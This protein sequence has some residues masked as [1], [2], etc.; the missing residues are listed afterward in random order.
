MQLPKELI[1]EFVKATKD[2]TKPSDNSILYGTATVEAGGAVYVAID[3]STELTPVTKAATVND[4]ERVMVTIKDHTATIVGN[5]SSP[6]ARS[7]DVEDLGA[8]IGEFDLVIADKVSTSQLAAQ[9]ARIDELVADNVTIKGDLVANKASIENLEAEDVKING[10]LEAQKASIDE[11]DTKKIDAETV[12][13]EYATIEKLNAANASIKNLEAEDVKINGTLDAQKAVI[14]TLDTTYATIKNLNATNAEVANLKADK[15]DADVVEATYATIEKLNATNANVDNLSA[16]HGEFKELTTDKFEAID[17]TIDNLDSTYATV[18]NLNAEKARIDD[19]EANSLTANHAVIKGLEADVADINTLIFGSAS[20]DVIQTSFA[21]AVIA[22]LGD[23][24]IKSAMIDNVSANKIIAG[25]IIT[26]N[27]SVKSEDGK[28]LI[29]DETI[30]ISDDARVRVQIGKDAAGDYSINIWDAEGNLMFSE[31]GITDNSIKEAI[32]RNDMVKDDANIS[33]SKLDISSLF[34]EINGSNETIKANRIYLDEENQTLDVSFTQ[35]T[36][37]MEDLDDR[38]VSQGTQL[39]V[40]QGQISSKVWQQDIN[41]ATDELGG[42]INTLNTNYSSLNQTVNGLKTTVASHTTQIASKADGSTVTAVSNK[43]TELESNLDGFKSTV[44]STYATAEAVDNIRIGGR[45]LLLN[46][47]TFSG[48]NI[49]VNQDA[50]IGGTYQGLNIYAHDFSKATSGSADILQFKQIYPEKLGAEY[51]LSFYAKGSG[52]MFTYFYGDTGYLQCAT[53]TRS[54]GEVTHSGDGSSGWSLTDQWTRYWVTWK[55]KDTGDITVQK[56]VL[57]RLLSGAKV[58]LCGIQLEKGNKASDWSP[59][60]EDMAT[61]GDLESTSKSI[62]QQTANSITAEV[63]SISIGGR[64]LLLN[65]NEEAT[66]N[67]YCIKGYV[68]SSPLV[69]GEQYTLS[70]CVTPAAGV[71]SFKA[72][73][74]GGYVVLGNLVVDGTE[75]QVLSC[76]F[77]AQY[78][79]GRTPTDDKAYANVR[80]YR[81]P[82]D[83]TVTANST[84]HWAKVEKGNK[85]TDWSPAPEEMASSKDLDSLEIGGRNLIAGTDKTTEYVGNKGTSTYKDVWFATTIEPPKGTEYIVSF[86]AKA[87][88]AQD[89][90]CFFYNPN[91]TVNAESSTGQTRAGADGQCSVTITTEWKRYWVKWTQTAATDPKDVIVGRNET[92][93][94]IYIRAVKFEAGNKATDWTPAPEDT[95]KDIAELSARIEVNEDN[96]K[97]QVS[98]TNTLKSK[99]STLE[100]R[101]DGFDVSIEDAKKSATDF[102]SYDG[103]NGLQVG[104]KQGTEW[105]GYRA[106]IKPDSFNILDADGAQ[107]A[108][109]GANEV[110]IGKNSQDTKIRFCNGKTIIDYDV[111][112]NYS[113]IIADRIALKGYQIASLSSYTKE[114]AGESYTNTANIHVVSRDGNPMAQINAARYLSDADGVSVGDIQESVVYIDYDGIVAESDD[115]IRLVAPLVNIEGDGNVTGELSANSASVSGALS[116]ASASVTGKVSAGSA[117]ISGNLTAANGTST[118]SCIELHRAE[119]YIDFHYGNSTKDFTQRIIASS[120]GLK[121]YGTTSNYVVIMSDRFRSSGDEV[122]YLGDSSCKWLAVYAKNGTIQSSDRNQKENI[123]PIDDRYITLFDKLQPVTFE[124]NDAESDRV[125]IGFISQDVKT[126]M[127]EVGLTD[128]DFAGY[129]RDVKMETVTVDD[130]E[131]GETKEVEREVLDENGDPVYSYSLRYS[132]FIALNTRMIQLNKQKIAEQEQEIESLRGEVSALKEM[133]EKLLANQ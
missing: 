99:T 24:Q 64:N 98:E 79:D 67:E 100:Q 108:S 66:N 107:L 96:I 89:I 117:S 28:L 84:I 58:S 93:N 11:L 129:C 10:T 41:S 46:S 44:S 101:A 54:I 95:E 83:G 116:A 18:N 1:S 6:A 22:Q 20:G 125:H 50:V 124:F 111:S 36:S 21:N 47:N 26:N 76:P 32:I 72:F 29:S 53:V 104:K 82:N 78:A 55:L 80:I 48:D 85:A 87:D 56:F 7:G 75:K 120:G 38:V 91:T 57:F 42:E 60:P 122:H 4:G 62:L 109:Y 13:A 118:L 113:Q 25:D 65:S 16:S 5:M 14:D 33:A 127:D 63:R 17:A 126:A 37:D 128:L 31:G 35:M 103:T 69:E 115:S 94:N 19:L 8:K 131:T 2:E 74:S 61:I 88:V 23:A 49:S 12:K 77:T 105:T 106:Q 119:P 30:Q 112:T 97:T 45:N 39:E 121:L 102:L 59:A 51:T 123:V 73:L 132:E 34:T 114:S 133:V 43:V 27:V 81:F 71:E 52:N 90:K 68:P 3:G 9:V 92:T 70:I 110:D 86:D 130:P 15:I 40:V